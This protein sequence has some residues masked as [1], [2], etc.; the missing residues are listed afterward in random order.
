MEAKHIHT[1]W[2][3]TT[4]DKNLIGQQ[5]PDFEG[6]MKRELATK[7]MSDL[8]EK[9]HFC[10]ETEADG[11]VTFKA[12]LCWYDDQAAAEEAQKAERITP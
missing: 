4:I 12:W 1:A 9:I 5:D 11:S 2:A 7:I 6:W 3:E 10:K 8:L